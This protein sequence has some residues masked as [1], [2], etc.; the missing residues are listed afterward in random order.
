MCGDDRDCK[1]RE[2]EAAIR[3][4][5]ALDFATYRELVGRF[6]SAPEKRL[7]DSEDWQ[8]GSIGRYRYMAVYRYLG[9]HAG[10]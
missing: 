9:Q 10:E 8:S 2:R 1:T 5:K 4:A 7:A 3:N 6:L